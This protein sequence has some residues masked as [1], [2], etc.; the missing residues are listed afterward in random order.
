MFNPAYTRH[1]IQI[2]LQTRWGYSIKSV[3]SLGKKDFEGIIASGALVVSAILPHG[4]IDGLN[5]CPWYYL[6][7]YECPF[8]GMTRGFVAITHL[9]PQSAIEFNPGTPL[10][11]AAFIVV[12][13]RSIIPKLKSNFEIKIPRSIYQLWLGSSIFVFAYVAWE[14]L[15]S[16][17]I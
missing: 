12:A 6:T 7:G 8:C 9:D 3:R 17:L 14:R 10:I 11:Y 2:P 5:L 1:I 16:A 4:D 15:I 13:L